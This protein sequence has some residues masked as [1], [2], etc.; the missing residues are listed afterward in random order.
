[1]SESTVVLYHRTTPEA[2]AAV[3]ASGCMVSRENTRE[4]YFSTRRDGH[5][6]GY[7]EGVVAVAVHRVHAELDDE[8]P[9]GE[10]HYRV[11]AA[12]INYACLVCPWCGS[13]EGYREAITEGGPGDCLTCHGSIVRP[14]QH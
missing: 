10:R 2:A 4:A 7:G 14:E 9:D 5:A 13:R 12:L 3:Y 6:E 1:M 11:L 8:F